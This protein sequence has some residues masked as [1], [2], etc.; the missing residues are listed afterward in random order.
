[1]SYNE[2][3]STRGYC[4]YNKPPI[5]PDTT[6]NLQRVVDNGYKLQGDLPLTNEV[7]GFNG[8][9][10]VWGNFGSGGAQS[11]QD[12]IDVSDD[13]SGNGPVSGKVITFDGSRVVWGD[14]STPT[15]QAVINAG[16]DLSGNTP[17]S[18]QV[19]QYDG[20]RVVWTNLTT[21]TLDMVLAAGN[22]ANNKTAFFTNSPQTTQLSSALFEMKDE[23]VGT[24]LTTLTNTITPTFSQQ[25]VKFIDSIVNTEAE[26]IIKSELNQTKTSATVSD[27]SNNLFSVRN[28]SN[29]GGTIVDNHSSY[30]PSISSPSK[31]VRISEQIDQT[32]AI[33]TTYYTDISLGDTTLTEQKSTGTSSS[34]FVSA[35]GSSG[36]SAHSIRVETPVTGGAL[37]QHGVTGA[38][39]DLTISTT[40]NL[41][42]TADNI[43]LSANGNFIIPNLTGGDYMNYNPTT[44]NL[45]LASNNAGGGVNPMLTLNQ[46]DVA[47]GSASMKFYK[48]RSTNGS[49][50]GELSFVA[51]SSFSTN[52]EY[53][54]IDGTIRN[55][56][57][58]N[59]DG[60]ISLRTRVDNVLTELVRV[61]GSSNKTEFYQSIDMSGNSI[62]TSTGNMSITTTGSAGTGNLS[63]LAKANLQI[64]SGTDDIDITSNTVISAQKSLS[65]S[66]SA[67][68]VSTQVLNGESIINSDLT[69]L[70]TA[71]LDTNA[72]TVAGGGS[73]TI[74]SQTGFFNSDGSIACNSGNGFRMIG[75]NGSSTQDLS[76]MEIVNTSSTTDTIL[77]QNTGG[78]NPVLDLETTNSGLNLNE[79]GGMSVNGIGF[80]R[81]DLS[82]SASSSLSLNNDSA[83]GGV[84]QFQNAINTNPLQII[85]DQ[86]I[87]ISAN[88]SQAIQLN[89]N[90]IELNG[91][92]L[93]VPSSSGTIANYLQI[94]INGNNYV[95]ALLNP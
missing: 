75:V 58:P 67:G 45:T 81:T 53:A 2:Y 32:N 1:M 15:L 89:S 9:N 29:I 17:S 60:S 63:L 64:S 14:V 46:N 26:T 87:E 55:N 65:L 12:V 16:D 85:S 92:S 52:T 57:S 10:V 31:W 78:G 20:V 41:I 34:L 39:R 4:N 90:S 74:Y 70:T 13:L 91:S 62:T 22:T 88:P 37:I 43:D 69:N 40:G 21:P 48:N 54:R 93:V 35:S 68:I 28:D 24:N 82:S 72:L 38:S 44:P 66:K 76:K 61:N 73:S 95:I 42:L 47:A 80:T 83:S 8:T 18:G 33:H 30:Y 56:T 6:T 27:L 71:T 23:T 25:S 36:T 59:I 86:R 7:M 19:I 77:L 3:S 50:I 51:V 79:S 94:M 84:I 5:L 49:A 11:L